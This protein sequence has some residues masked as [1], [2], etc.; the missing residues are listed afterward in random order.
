MRVALVVL[1]Q[2][3]LAVVV[4]VRRTDDGEVLPGPE[5]S[6]DALLI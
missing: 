1:A 4:A 3:I 2:Q 6:V 5:I